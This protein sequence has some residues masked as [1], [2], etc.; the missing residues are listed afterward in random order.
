MYKINYITT[1]I[2]QNKSEI[3]F[4]KFLK[5]L[6]LFVQI[7]IVVLIIQTFNLYGKIELYNSN[8]DKVKSVISDKRSSNYMNNIEKDWT[9]SYYKIQAVKQLLSNRSSYGLMLKNFAEHIP[10]DSH[11]SNISADKDFCMFDLEFSKQNKIKYPNIYKYVDELKILFD[12]TAYFDKNQMELLNN[13]EQKINDNMTDLL[14]IK[15]WCKT[16]N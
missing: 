15:I 1:V 7:A 6:N 13:K 10:E 5:I 14:E 12:K 11:V 8:I 3:V 2:K 9:M 4:L 16:R